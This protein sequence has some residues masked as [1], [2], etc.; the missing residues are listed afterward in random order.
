MK[1]YYN[2][3][4]G[5]LYLYDEEKFYVFDD[6]A[7]A[8]F[9]IQGEEGDY[10]LSFGE[11]GLKFEVAKVKTPNEI[12]YKTL[13]NEGRDY[14]IDSYEVIR[15][16][17]LERNKDL[18]EELLE[19]SNFQEQVSK[20]KMEYDADKL[21]ELALSEIIELTDTNISKEKL[22]LLIAY[23]FARGPKKNLRYISEIISNPEFIKKVE[24]W[25]NYFDNQDQKE[26]YLYLIIKE[27][28]IQ[29]EN[30]NMS[31]SRLKEILRYI[32]I[33]HYYEKDKEEY[34]EDIKKTLEKH[35]K[36]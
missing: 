11:R 12:V 10:K 28:L 25:N 5:L 16:K 18:V 4:K 3:I 32:Y 27:S 7:D 15:D 9:I 22:R 8:A 21:K 2:Y 6:Y 19:D 26:K 14:L 20:L 31:I 30:E 23:F 33:M 35:Q 17:I 1:K 29:C 34:E 13:E 36:F 24:D